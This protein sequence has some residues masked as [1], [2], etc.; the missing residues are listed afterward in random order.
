MRAHVLIS[1]ISLARESNSLMA[2][3]SLAN[4]IASASAATAAARLVPRPDRGAVAPTLGTG[5]GRKDAVEE[6]RGGGVAVMVG[7]RNGPAEEE[8][9]VGVGMREGAEED[10]VGRTESGAA[11]LAVKVRDEVEADDGICWL[12][13]GGDFPRTDG[14]IMMGDSS[15]GSSFPRTFSAMRNMARANCSA[16]SLP[17][18]RVSHRFLWGDAGRHKKSLEHVLIV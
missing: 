4:P 6:R 16:F 5:V 12:T 17:L 14:G 7:R 2:E 3:K 10:E 8:E 15:F 13:V 9:A 18:F 1:P 11:P